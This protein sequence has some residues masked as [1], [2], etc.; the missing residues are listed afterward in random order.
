MLTSF[1]HRQNHHASIF[2]KSMKTSKSKELPLPKL[3]K[4]TQDIFNAF[5]R[6]RDKDKGCISCC[7]GPV[8]QAGHYFSQGHH[9]ALRLNEVNT[10]GQC[11]HCNHFLS[12]NL[13]HYRAGL[14]KRY[15]EPRVLHLESCARRS[16]KKWSRCELMALI[17]Y[18]KKET[19][20]LIA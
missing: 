18:Y 2:R 8:E 19:Q 11:V 15:G 14:V 1:Y 9:S 6:I 10:N 5:I 16:V 12:G 4:K 7:V 13:I 17:E 20:K 3:L